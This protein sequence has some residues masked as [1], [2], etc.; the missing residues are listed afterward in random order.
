MDLTSSLMMM[1]LLVLLNLTQIPQTLRVTQVE[2]RVGIK[3][4]TFFWPLKVALLV[5]LSLTV[6]G[7]VM[8][9]VLPGVEDT[10]LMVAACLMNGTLILN[11]VQL[12]REGLKNY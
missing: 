4:A 11:A 3:I 2:G 5:S 9:W 7:A 10:L 8:P 12:I 6:M 1:A